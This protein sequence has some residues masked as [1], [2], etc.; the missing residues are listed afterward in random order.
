MAEKIIQSYVW[1]GA[2]CFFV[3]T[4]NRAS[5]AREAPDFVYAETLIW[6]YDYDT[7]ERG[8]LLY[9]Q[10]D[11]KDCIS[12]HMRACEDLHKYGIIKGDVEDE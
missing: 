12:T 11:T 10:D 3:S 4:I 9:Q 8:A 6:K 5:S 7:R 1:H 2:S